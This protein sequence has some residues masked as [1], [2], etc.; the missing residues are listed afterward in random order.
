MLTSFDADSSGHVRLATPDDET[1]LMDMLRLM[2]AEAGLRDADGRPFPL[3][4]DRVRAVVQRAIIPNRNDP[5]SGQSCC[6]VIGG[7]GQA[8][9]AGICL[10]I[11][12]TWYSEKP[13]IGDF[14]S[15]V[16]PDFRRGGHAKALISFAKLVAAAMNMPLSLGNVSADR[17]AAKDRFLERNL[18]VKRY[19]STYLYHPTNTIG[20]A[21]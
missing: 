21:I 6:G 9:E 17:A 5:D 20:G 7:P 10:A 2:H 13:Y 3:C 19:G 4:E 14:F 11:T 18:G 1:P 16:T 12:A 8:I 15:Y